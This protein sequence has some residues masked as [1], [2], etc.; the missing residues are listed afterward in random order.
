MVIFRGMAFLF[1]LVTCLSG[2]FCSSVALGLLTPGAIAG[3]RCQGAAREDEQGAEGDS[4]ASRGHG[5][6]CPQH[7]SRKSTATLVTTA[8]ISHWPE[9]PVQGHGAEAGLGPSWEFKQ[10]FEMRKV[11]GQAQALPEKCV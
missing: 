3:S 4:K 6:A 7:P 2:C 8:R 5:L 10:Q 9:M 1:R 11:H